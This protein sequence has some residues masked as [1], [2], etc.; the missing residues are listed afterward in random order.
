MLPFRE[1]YCRKGSYC[2]PLDSA[3]IKDTRDWFGKAEEDLSA[4][5]TLFS[6]SPPVISAILFLCQQ[7]VEKSLKGFLIFHDVPFKK[8]HDVLHVGN[9][10]LGIDKSLE[11][12]IHTCVPLSQYAWQF[13]LQSRHYC[14]SIHSKPC[15][16]SS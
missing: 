9:K 7:A 11:E 10:C 14:V 4:A 8:T 1:R 5:K 13:R 3:I 6:A 2:M 16:I 12:I 15:P